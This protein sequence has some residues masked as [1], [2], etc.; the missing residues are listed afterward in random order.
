MHLEGTQL[1]NAPREI[2]WNLLNDPQVI[3]RITP[4]VKT[5]NW[6]EGDRYEAVFHIKLGPINAAFT[7]QLEVADKAPPERYR[8]LVKVD[9]RIGAVAAEGAVSLAAQGE[10]TLL[11]FAGDARLSGLLAGKGQ[12]VLSGVAQLFTRNFFRSLE[13]ELSRTSPLI[14]G[15]GSYGS[16]DQSHNQRPDA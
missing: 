11:A 15:G 1:F 12:R 4:G 14:A 3:A 9:S 8:L 13:E 16:A 10:A 6:V 7:G 2:L 5:L